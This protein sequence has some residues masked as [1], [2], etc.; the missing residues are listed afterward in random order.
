MLRTTGDGS[1]TLFSERYNETYHSTHG[2]VTESRHVFLDASGVSSRLESGCATRI[3][4]I[5]FGL[6]LNT[7]ISADAALVANTALEFHSLEND[8]A[9]FEQ[10]RN[11]H[12]EAFLQHPELAEGL[13][14]GLLSRV[15]LPDSDAGII[16]LAEKITLT[17]HQA[18]A[19]EWCMRQP[20]TAPLLFDAVYLD[21]FSPDTN[22]ECWAPEFFNSIRQLMAPHAKLSTYSAKGSVRRSLLAAGFR[23]NKMPGP[24]GK[25]EM[26]V[27]SL[28][29][30]GYS[31]S[32]QNQACYSR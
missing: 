28:Q 12:Y 22:P 27:A 21:A 31:H 16:Q 11:L 26:M 15:E 13:R 30:G 9:V 29:G 32:A 23:V 14:A 25:R 19:V 1:G 17:I 3:L 8:A 24:P 18:D 5:G 2:A 4:E 6:G 10:A 20:S 7:L